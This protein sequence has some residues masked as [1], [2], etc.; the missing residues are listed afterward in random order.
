MSRFD[1]DLYRHADQNGIIKRTH[2]SQYR[3]VAAAASLPSIWTRE[4]S[5]RCSLI[6]RE[7][8]AKLPEIATPSASGRAM[9]AIRT[10][11]ELRPLP[12]R[13]RQGGGFARFTNDGSLVLTV[14]ADGKARTMFPSI[15]SRPGRGNATTPKT[16]RSSRVKMAGEEDDVF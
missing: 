5:L 9:P 12:C 3:N 13:G 4:I 6:T 16:R 7:T 8:A 15:A 11:E 2:L 14:S 10:P 1:E